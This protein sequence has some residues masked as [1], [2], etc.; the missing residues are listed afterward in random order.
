MII[1]YDNISL[2]V[3]ISVQYERGRVLGRKSAEWLGIVRW[4]EVTIV[5][6]GMDTTK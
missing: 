6:F 1:K 4:L 2:L 3:W 5:I